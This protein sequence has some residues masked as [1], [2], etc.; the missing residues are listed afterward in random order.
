[1]SQRRGNLKMQ[2]NETAGR[3]DGEMSHGTDKHPSIHSLVMSHYLR[4]SRCGAH[5]A[6]TSNAQVRGKED[7]V[8]EL[9]WSWSGDRRRWR[10]LSFSLFLNRGLF[11][12][13]A[14]MMRM[15]IWTTLK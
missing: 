9:S 14:Y 10:R 13:C 15:R 8:R 1:M 5:H 3:T 11:I 2:G 7:A 4:P 12:S 6:K